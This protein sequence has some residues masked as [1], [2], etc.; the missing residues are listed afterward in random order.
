MSTVHPK[1]CVYMALKHLGIGNCIARLQ[2]SEKSS[3]RQK[4]AR[5]ISVQKR[6]KK[7]PSDC[8]KLG[9]Y[10]SFCWFRNIEMDVLVWVQIN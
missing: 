2:Q 3:E 5:L 8:A 7:G 6:V 1:P 9:S 10:P 4:E